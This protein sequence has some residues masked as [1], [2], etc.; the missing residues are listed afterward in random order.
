M[1]NQVGE[2]QQ[3]KLVIA[4]IQRRDRLWEK[5][6]VDH[7]TYTQAQIEAKLEQFGA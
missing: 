5:V 2:F 1:I 3:S 6:R 7:P 4:Y